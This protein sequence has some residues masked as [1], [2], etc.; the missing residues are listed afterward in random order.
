MHGGHPTRVRKRYTGIHE[1]KTH[2][3]NSV[4]SLTKMYFIPGSYGFSV[5]EVILV[6][7]AAYVSTGPLRGR[8]LSLCALTRLTLLPC[9][10]RRQ[11]LLELNRACNACT[12]HAGTCIKYRVQLR[13]EHPNGLHRSRG[14]DDIIQSNDF[15]ARKQHTR[16]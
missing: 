10:L 12:W 5:S 2:H 9:F 13:R 14:T 8:P 1:R 3:F 15:H 6:G 16:G 4:S 7:L 11:T